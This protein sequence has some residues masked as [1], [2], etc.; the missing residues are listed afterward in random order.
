MTPISNEAEDLLD[1][2]E[3][4][5]VRSLTWGFVDGSLSLE[6]TIA[7]AAQRGARNPADVVEKLVAA[8]LVF[9]VDT[10]AGDTRIRSRFG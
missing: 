6:A 5:E 3:A 7:L 4:L 2:I 10:P 1:Q 9:E 8:R